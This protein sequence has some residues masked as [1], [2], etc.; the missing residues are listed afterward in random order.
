MGNQFL[1]EDLKKTLSQLQNNLTKIKSG[2]PAAEQ[3]KLNSFQQ[4]LNATMQF[5]FSK[6][7]PEE[8][9]EKTEEAKV[10]ISALLQEHGVKGFT[11]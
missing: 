5:D 2:L 1:G 6:L 8:I 4:K 9:M 10:S 7:S 3:I 11:A